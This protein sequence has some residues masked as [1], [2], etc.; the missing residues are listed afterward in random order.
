MEDPLRDEASFIE[1]GLVSV[2]PYHS[3]GLWQTIHPVT[4][5]LQAAVRIAGC[6]KSG[7]ARFRATSPSAQ[8]PE[9]ISYTSI[10]ECS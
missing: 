3:V 1:C 2:H 5:L 6:S 9:A 10:S 4:F 8:V 7:V